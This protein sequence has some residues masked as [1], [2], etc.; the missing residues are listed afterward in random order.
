MGVGGRWRWGG[1]G[2]VEM[3]GG[4]GKPYIHTHKHTKYC[5]VRF[6]VIIHEMFLLFLVHFFFRGGGG[7]NLLISA[8]LVEM[9]CQPIM[10]ESGTMYTI[11]IIF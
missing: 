10:T 2:K 7:N 5:V 1:G 4:G 11:L 6:N 3:G 8:S 9:W